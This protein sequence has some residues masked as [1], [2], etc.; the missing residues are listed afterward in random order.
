ME[1]RQQY[2]HSLLLH[3]IDSYFDVTE[4]LH[5]RLFPL[6]W[7]SGQKTKLRSWRLLVAMQQQMQFTNLAYLQA[8]GNRQ[9]MLQLKNGPITSGMYLIS[10]G[11]TPEG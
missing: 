10:P 5:I 7:T 3:H 8:Q 4:M 1:K 9:Q 11:C 6:H 2:L